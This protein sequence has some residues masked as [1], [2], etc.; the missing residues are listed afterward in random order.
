[1]TYAIAMFVITSFVVVVLISGAILLATDQQRFADLFRDETM[2]SLQLFTMIAPFAYFIA[3]G[4]LYSGYKSST[5][6]T[7]AHKLLD[8]YPTFVNSFATSMFIVA[9]IRLVQVLL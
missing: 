3:L 6:K 7:T 9:I 8:A 4:E 5:A 2:T 1:M